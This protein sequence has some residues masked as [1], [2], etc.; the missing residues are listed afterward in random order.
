MNEMFGG[1]KDE[2]NRQLTI[3]IKN[4]IKKAAIKAY[5]VKKKDYSLLLDKLDFFSNE[6]LHLLILVAMA[7]SEANLC[8]S[9]RFAEEC[10]KAKLI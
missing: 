2:N 3:L 10:I 5:S 8:Y 7:R 6:L 9:A 4:F 1:N